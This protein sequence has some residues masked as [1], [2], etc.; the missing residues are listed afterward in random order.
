MSRRRAATKRVCNADHVYNSIIVTK[1][2][3]Y[4]ML[5]GKQRLAEKIFY[6]ALD[7]AINKVKN[8]DI[9]YKI[10]NNESSSSNTNRYNK[11]N[12][13]TPEITTIKY[14]KE[15]NLEIYEEQ[16]TL[17]MF[18][19]AMNN[20]RPIVEVRSRRVG[21]STYQVPIKT[22]IVRSISLAM[23]W[24]LE[25]ARNRKGKSMDDCLATEL[26]EA[27]QGRGNAVK[28]REDMHRMAKA[29]QAFA[30]FIWH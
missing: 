20:V 6:S 24:L 9:Q 8:A 30:Y 13:V 17:K 3:N 11:Q 12:V 22:N 25:A 21:G 19:V 16:E 2:I 5:D 29:N 28:K 1:F 18:M 10:F 7:K 27:I 15:L 14:N 26:L 23:R 4:L